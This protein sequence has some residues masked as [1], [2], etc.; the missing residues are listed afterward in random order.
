ML[1]FADCVKEF[2]PN[3]ITDPEMQKYCSE[4]Y[5][6]AALMYF[7]PDKY[8]N[9]AHSD[10][11]DLILNDLIGIE[12][13]TCFEEKFNKIIGIWNNY[14]L[15]KNGM[16]FEKCQKKI[17]EQGG[18]MD[19]FGVDHNMSDESTQFVPIVKAI[20]SK[21]AKLPEYRTK[22]K[23]CSLAII[24]SEPVDTIPKKTIEYFK[25]K[26]KNLDDKFDSIIIIANHFLI[27]YNYK[28]D[29][30]THRIITIE[31]S[32][33]LDNIGTMVANKNVPSIKKCFVSSS[34]QR[35]L[36]CL[37]KIKNAIVQ[38][39]NMKVEKC[40]CDISK[41]EKILNSAKAQKEDSLFPDFIFEGGLIEHFEVT[42]SNEN[43]KG[44]EFKRYE[45]EF[46]NEMK[47]LFQKESEKFL[48]SPFSPNT[49]L[50]CKSG[51]TY[52]KTSYE[53]FVSSFKRNFDSHLIS[54]DKSNKATLITVFLIDQQGGRLQIYEK[55]E[56][57]R[58]Y[59]LSED[60]K[61]LLYLKDKYPKINYVIFTSVDSVEIIDM[62]KIEQ[63][64]ASSKDEMD[65]RG[66]RMIKPNSFVFIDL[67]LKQ[68]LK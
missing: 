11:P 4:Y 59:L 39:E 45:T 26:Q 63:L 2:K 7:Y 68:L 12:V 62:S 17:A 24:L 48:N 52:E 43:K 54:L 47:I 36:D 28:N 14:R 38:K 46:D 20:D 44:S 6:M 1:E 29:T 40:N 8:F 23:E 19:E 13:T 41:I 57:K 31:E 9:L 34:K 33:Y 42:S 65:I 5:V 22:Y 32:R 18:A 37:Q 61:L 53:Y 25:E 21:L 3:H 51:S 27:I 67:I 58:F 60:K 66:G 64:I 16:T 30:F 56:F 15:D 50:T 10:K 35:E 49:L 55:N